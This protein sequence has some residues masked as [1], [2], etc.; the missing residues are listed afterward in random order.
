MSDA[1]ISP[2]GQGQY[3]LSGEL[4]FR[5]VPGLLREGERLF[6]GCSAF[7]LDLQGVDRADSAGLALLLEWLRSCRRRQQDLYFRNLPQ[8]LVEIA[9]V[10]NLDEVFGRLTR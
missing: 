8:A 4:S 7:V 2:E 6:E 9:R 3:A 1:R 5:T 10:S